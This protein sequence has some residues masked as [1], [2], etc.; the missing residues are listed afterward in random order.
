MKILLLL[1]STITF[2][3]C[4]E[5]H[6]KNIEAE[7]EA[8]EELKKEA[9]DKEYEY[10]KSLPAVKDSARELSIQQQGIME[11]DKSFIFSENAEIGFKYKALKKLKYKMSMQQSEINAKYKLYSEAKKLG[12]DGVIFYK[13]TFEPFSVQGI[14]IK[15]E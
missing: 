13:L 14:P 1:V 8:R 15:K 6:K 3:S 10:L 4:K 9:E 11:K 12:A 7:N 2:I 5:F